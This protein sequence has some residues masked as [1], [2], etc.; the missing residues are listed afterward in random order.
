MAFLSIF[1]SK[2]DKN[3]AFNT[4]K[5]FW[6]KILITSCA[7]YSY[8]IHIYF[9]IYFDLWNSIHLVLMKSLIKYWFF[10][11]FWEKL[12]YNFSFKH[13]KQSK[14]LLMIWVLKS[15]KWIF[16][17]KQKKIIKKLFWIF[18]FT[19]TKRNL[20]IICCLKRSNQIQII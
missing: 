9:D 7:L 2:Y 13:I 3:I 17:I 4:I 18:Y 12:K 10:K 20:I 16:I 15:S 19:K 6:F 14:K 5:T 1:D 8:S 11:N